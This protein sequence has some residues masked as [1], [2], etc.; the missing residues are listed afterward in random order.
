MEETCTN[1]TRLKLMPCIRYATHNDYISFK[2]SL[3]SGLHANTENPP[4]VPHSNSW[5]RAGPDGVEGPHALLSRQAASSQAGDEEAEGSDVEA[6]AVSINIKCPITLLPMKDPVTSKKCPHSFEK[7]AIEE[8]INFSRTQT[9]GS[10]RRGVNDGTRAL[11]CPV[12][13]VVSRSSPT[14]H[15]ILS[16]FD[17]KL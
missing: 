9:G 7:S 17:P 11:R 2:K 16:L 4:P 14:C 8:M 15:W 13:S 10:G 12:C 3:H 6:V 1:T 5:F